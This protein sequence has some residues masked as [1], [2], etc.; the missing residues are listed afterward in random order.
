VDVF[1]P[2]VD[3]FSTMPGNEY[4]PMSGTSMAAPVV[5]GVAA[6]IRSQYPQLTAVQVKAIIERSAIPYTKKVRI[7]G[8]KKKV[9]LKELCK[10]GAVV[11]A[12]EALKLAGQVASGTV[13][14]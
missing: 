11:N 1:A 5:S 3:I 9:K 10:T 8:T 2:G 4:A 14:L 7:P 12:Y 6:L 13:T